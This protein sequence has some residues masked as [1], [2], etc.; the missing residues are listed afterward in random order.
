GAAAGRR[1]AR[2]P[3]QAAGRARLPGRCE[4]DPGARGQLSMPDPA[5]LSARLLVVD[6]EEANVD[7]LEQMLARA[8]YGNVTGTTDP[9]AALELAR[10]RP[11][12][13][14]LLD[15]MMPHLDGF[16]LMEQLRPLIEEALFLPILVLTADITPAAK[17]RALTAGAKDFLA[18]PFDRTELLLRIKNLLETRMLY[19]QLQEQTAALERLYQETLASVQL[20]DQTQSSS[21]PD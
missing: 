2:V 9:R 15:L 17:E 1:R 16:A 14:I 5:Y 11:P 13:L 18:K 19:R 10:E 3:D 6:D 12:S 21:S 7:L 8:G 20:R 4:R